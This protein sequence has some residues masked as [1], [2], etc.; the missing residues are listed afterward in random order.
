M[1]LSVC[2]RILA[3]EHAAEDAF[4]ATFLTLARKAGLIGRGQAVAAWLYRVAYRIAL[5]AKMDDARRV[6]RERIAGEPRA[7]RTFHHPGW[8]LEWEEL[9]PHLDAEIASLPEEYRSAFILCHLEGKT[10]EEAARELGCPVGTVQS[11]LS[12]ARARLRA[13]LRNQDLGPESIL[14]IFFI[15]RPQAPADLPPAL[16]K[17]VL[18]RVLPLRPAGAANPPPKRNAKRRTRRNL[19]RAAMVALLVLLFLALAGALAY[20]GLTAPTASGTAPDSSA[21]GACGCH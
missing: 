6:R 17:A 2:R 1:V 15:Q 4:Q 13:R 20:A 11:R 10:N 16:A 5:R 9:R 19:R 3:D 21:A 7:D 12:R 18:K 8:S 14:F